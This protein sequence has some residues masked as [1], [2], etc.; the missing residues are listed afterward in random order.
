MFTEKLPPHDL[1]A[2]EAVIGSILIDPDTLLKVAP[3][4][5]PE[6]FYGGKPRAVYE[7]CLALSQ[8][9][10][11]VNQVTVAH[12]LA[13]MGK[14]EDIGGNGYLAT[15]IASTPT[16]VH[17]EHYARIVSRLSTY[18][19]L[20]K[21]GLDIASLGYEA[22]PDTDTALSRAE[23][24]IFRI[25]TGRPLRGLLHLRQLLDRFLEESTAVAVPRPSERGAGPLA[26][27]F[28]GLDHILGGLQRSDLII[29]AARPSLGKS[30]LALNIALHNAKHL[31]ATV[32]IFSLEMSA[33]QVALR[34][35]AAEAGVDGH[36]LRLRL[37]TEA[38]ERRLLDAI[39]RLSDL[40]IYIDD[41]PQPTVRAIW[42]KAKRLQLERGLD[43]AIVDYLQL[44][45][46]GNG[47]AENR[48][49]EISEISRSLK[50]LARDL[51]IPVIAVSQLSRAVE[52][53][54]SHRPQLSDLRESGSIEQDADVVLFIYRE[55]L[56]ITKEEWER[57]HPGV[58]YPKNIGEV[59]VAKHRHGPIG[60]VHLYFND[61]YA[62]FE[63]P[64]T[65]PAEGTHAL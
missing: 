10:E 43:L 52:V 30:A 59:I 39:G 38:E 13:R 45:Q 53:R 42:A 37:Y 61:R 29:L 17:A 20:I 23:D 8:R 4:L 31:G 57:R 50:A 14:L 60:S 11:A 28:S 55:D 56:Y 19:A 25:R 41:T 51:N 54:P 58:P 15:I 7:A 47:R 18:R 65:P 48:V 35:L 22:P 40:P 63:E 36:R 9:G 26:T 3:L 5:R 1:Q 33:D 24:L 6:D 44:A 34:L 32:A 16:S 27:G 2:E 21:A 64:P 12:E 62:R 49:Q 46:A